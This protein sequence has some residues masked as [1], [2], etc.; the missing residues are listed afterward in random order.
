M[1]SGEFLWVG[2]HAALDLCNTQPV[3]DHEQQ[4]LLADFRDV[5]GWARGA[6]VEVPR[7]I[8]RRATPRGAEQTLRWARHLRQELRA[9][10]DPTYPYDDV[11]ALNALLA[12]DRG[13]FQL[14]GG[15]DRTV[16]VAADDDLVQFR[17]DVAAIVLDIFSFDLRL[18]RRCH[19]PACVLL[20]LDTSKSGRRVWCDMRTCG[21]RAKAAAHYDRTRRRQRS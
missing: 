4:E 5:A 7:S 3:I 12:R 21:N 15:D 10:L 16:H 18:V 2:N 14:R 9:I 20:F 17:L 8:E 6:G 13:S 1:N 19:N 11:G